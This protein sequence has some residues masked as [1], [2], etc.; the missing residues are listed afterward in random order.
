MKY[1]LLTY[2]AIK[3]IKTVALHTDFTILFYKKMD[4]I[5]ETA[6]IHHIVKKDYELTFKGII[7]RFI[8]NGFNRFNGIT[9]GKV[10]VEEIKGK[11]FIN[12]KLYFTEIF[13]L[14]S[15]FSIIPFLGFFETQ[16]FR[17]LALIIIWSIYIGNNIL[18]ANRI[19]SLF[20]IIENEINE[21]PEYKKEIEFKKEIKN[22]P[23]A[24]K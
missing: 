22:A 23:A 12:Y 3:E 9:K 15:F 5:L 19:E 7:F 18:A 14:C 10:K 8:W 4:K 17:I 13:I 16:L 11:L 21:I 6:Y 20:E 2:S 1:S 24:S